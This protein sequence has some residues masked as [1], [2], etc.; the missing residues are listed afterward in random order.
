MGL[1][2]RMDGL[3]GCGTRADLIGKRRQAEVDALAGIAFALAIE[4]LMLGELLEQDHRQKVRP[5]KA[6][7]CHME[8]CW[9]LRDLLAF[10]AG[11]LL[12]HR[13]N[14]FPLTRDDLQG[15]CDILAKLP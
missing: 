4:R 2:Q 11:E 8:G 10:A 7:G 9:R 12:P 1:D 6:A 13:L 5:G 3:E 14:D 15:L